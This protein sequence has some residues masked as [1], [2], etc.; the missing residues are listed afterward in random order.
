MGN[1][2]EKEDRSN[3]PGIGTRKKRKTT[4]LPYTRKNIEATISNRKDKGEIDHKMEKSQTRKQP[5]MRNDN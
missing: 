3:A 1:V 2:Q 5:N 4:S